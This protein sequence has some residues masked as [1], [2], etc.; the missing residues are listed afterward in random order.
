MLNY[1]KSI[2]IAMKAH[3]AHKAYKGQ[4]DKGGFPYILH[5]LNIFFKV[6]G[7]D[8]KVVALLHDVLEDS[9][10]ELQDLSFLNKEQRE[11]LGLMTKG[12]D[13]DYFDYIDKIKSN[14]IA[15][16][17]KLRDLEH[18]MDTSRLQSLST[19]DYERLKKYKKAFNILQN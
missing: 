13:M 12:E 19:K 17:V 11:A 14:K 16:Q 7:K 6:R 4:E 15:R 8:E 10:Y 2:L 5:P 1:I 3:K 9:N 18:N